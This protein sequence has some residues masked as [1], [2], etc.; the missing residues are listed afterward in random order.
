MTDRPQPAA[1]KANRLPAWTDGPR[2]QMAQQIREETEKFA[3]LVEGG[4]GPYRVN[5]DT[6]R[7]GVPRA[8]SSA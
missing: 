4:E 6:A 3:K 1:L 2:E 8:R 7:A 5:A